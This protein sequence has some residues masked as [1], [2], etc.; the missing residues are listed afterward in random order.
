MEILENRFDLK[1]QIGVCLASENVSE[2]GPVIFFL[3]K[4]KKLRIF[5]V[6]YLKEMS[7][8]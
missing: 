2:V 1:I 4:I 7:G 5:K 3:S 6:I 8:R